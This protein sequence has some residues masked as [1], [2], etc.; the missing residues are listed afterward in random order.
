M[1]LWNTGHVTGLE[2]T[3]PPKTYLEIFYQACFTW[4][5]VLLSHGEFSTGFGD[6]RHLCLS[7]WKILAPKRLC[8]LYPPSKIMNLFHR[9]NKKRKQNFNLEQVVNLSCLNMLNVFPILQEFFYTNNFSQY[10]EWNSLEKD[11]MFKH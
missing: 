10:P 7:I 11:L 1:Y 3:P 5:T 8:T 9:Y 6:A 2:S 4:E